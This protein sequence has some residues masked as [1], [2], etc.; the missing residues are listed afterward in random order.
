MNT[1]VLAIGAHPDDLELSCGGTIAKLVLQ[2]RSVVMAD[3]TQ[4]ELGTRGTK[5]IRLKESAHAARILGVA[6]RRN[7]RI[8]DG[9]VDINDE[10]LRTVISLIRDVRPRILLIPHSIERHP[11]HVH[12]HQLCKEAW[13]YSGLAKLPTKKKGKMQEPFRPHAFFEFI[14]WYEVQS[15]FVVDVSETFETKMK[16]IRAYA[17]QFHNPLVK[18]RETKLSHPDFLDTIEMRFRFYGNKIGVRYGEPFFHVGEVGVQSIF[19]LVTAGG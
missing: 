12:A 9:H 5:E 15:S 10:N 11:D 18:E 4:G 7:L 2:G 16:A 17:S 19:D 14:Q 13:F 6:D 1:D 8:P 3:L